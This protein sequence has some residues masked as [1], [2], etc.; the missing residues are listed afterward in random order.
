MIRFFMIMLFAIFF[1]NTVSAETIKDHPTIAVMQFA[2]KAIKSDVEGIRGQDFSCA[3]ELA[4]YQLD[5]S[6]WFDIVDY[7]QLTAVARM[8]SMYQSG[9]F[10]QSAAP[11]IGKFATARY[12]LVGSLTGMTVKESGLKIG[13]KGAGVGASK[14]TVT[15]N[16][17]VRFVDVETLKVCG[18]GTGTGKSSSTAAEITFK[19]FR[20]PTGFIGS[21]STNINITIEDKNINV[22]SS[23]FISTDDKS[24]GEYSI[25][26]GSAEVSATQVRNALGKAVMDAIYGDFGIL[27]KLNDGK[28][29]KVKT[30]FK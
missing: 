8:H 20:N 3:T 15:A 17:S 30:T 5:A 24:F 7:E 26:I 18:T 13:A 28:K 16:V 22:N 14:H 11:M 9:L 10:D 2:D 6:N 21:K 27:T 23:G 19:P 25:L 29:L 12:I 4:L 1:M